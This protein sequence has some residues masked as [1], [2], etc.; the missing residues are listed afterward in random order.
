[1]KVMN[2]ELL[3]RTSGKKTYELTREV[4][5]FV[6]ES[7]VQEGQVTVF[8]C[9]T[10]ASLVI[11]ENADP[12]ARDDLEEFFERLVPEETPWFTHTYEGADDMPSHI[13]MAL[14]GTSEVIPIGNGRMVLG[15]WQGVFLF[16]HRRASH[17][18]KVVISVMGV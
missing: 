3:V 9:H 14:T 7:G 1:M 8:V 5:Q 10:S 17:Q 15:T 18:R 6:S 4:K 12:E 16:E 2:E 11:M 13:R